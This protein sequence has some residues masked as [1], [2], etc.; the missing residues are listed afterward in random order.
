MISFT[1]K[2][3]IVILILVI[4]II[5]IVGLN[6]F[7]NKNSSSEILIDKNETNQMYNEESNYDIDEDNSIQENIMVHITGA[8]KNPGLI[9]LNKDSRINDVVKKAGGLTEDADIN[10]INLAKKVND[11]EKIHIYS[12]NEKKVSFIQDEIHSNENKIN[13]NL[14][15]KSQ[16]E[17]LDGIGTVKAQR[18]VEYRTKNSFKS[19]EEITKVTGIGNKTFDRIKD[20]IS[21]N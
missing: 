15:S 9:E 8:V 14:A 17:K 16:L 13:I 18:I 11:E 12:I 5:S 4:T 19:I 20:K 7:L 6:L 10:R 21:I 1:R 2:E 3:Q